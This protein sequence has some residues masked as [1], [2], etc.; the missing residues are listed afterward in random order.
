[1]TTHLMKRDGC[2]LPFKSESIKEAN[3]R[4]AEITGKR[5]E[6]TVKRHSQYLWITCS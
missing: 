6:K 3:L 4:A 5:N 2:K 1:M